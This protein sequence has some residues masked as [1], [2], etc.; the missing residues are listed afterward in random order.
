MNGLVVRRVSDEE[1]DEVFL[2][3]YDSWGANL[4][5][6]MYLE[7]CHASYKY[8]LGEF[9]VLEDE[10]GNFLSS[11]IV[12]SLTAFGGVVSENAVG[13][14]SLATSATE[15]HKGYATLLLSQLMA[16]L[17]QKGVDAFFIHS[18]IHPKMYQ[19]LGFEPAPE[20]MRRTRDTSIPM[21]RLSKART[22]T[23]EL[24]SEIVLPSYF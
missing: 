3:G 18:D 6:E 15:R 12:Y 22:I 9:Y 21:L 13:L 5:V 8:K 11:C 17:E 14:G 10:E 19:N 7:S 2:M 24:W 4:P 16:A 23:P 1:L 20:S